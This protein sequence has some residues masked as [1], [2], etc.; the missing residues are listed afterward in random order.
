MLIT[1]FMMTR[2][3]S[4]SWTF[5]Q[6]SGCEM[7]TRMQSG[8]HLFIQEYVKRVQSVNRAPDVVLNNK[9]LLLTWTCISECGKGA[10]FKCV[11]VNGRCILQA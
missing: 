5:Q 10:V 7:W 8:A 6:T 2:C 9:C 1:E 3:R 4:A 11:G